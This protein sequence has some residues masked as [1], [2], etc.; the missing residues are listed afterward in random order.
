MISSKLSDVLAKRDPLVDFLAAIRRSWYIVVVTSLIVGS[1]ALGY[2]LLQQP[3]YRASATLYVTSAPE[4]TVQ[5]AYQGSLASQQRIESYVRL[6]DSTAVVK[7]AVDQSGLQISVPD[8][9]AMIS[10]SA[11]PGTVLLSVSVDSTEPAHAKILADS[12]AQSMSEYVSTLESP[13][14]GGSPLA[15]LT[16]VNPASVGKGYV[17]PRT[18]RVTSSALVVGLIMGIFFVFLLARLRG[19]VSSRSQVE[20]SSGVA[21]LSEIPSSKALS[22]NTGGSVSFDEGFSSEAEAFRRLRANLAFADVDKPRRVL[23]VTSASPS[24]GKTTISLNLATALSESGRRVLLVEG[25]LRRPTLASRLGLS[26]APGVSEVVRGDLTVEEASHQLHGGLLSVLT[27]GSRV[28]NP[29]ELVGSHSMGRLLQELSSGYEFVVVDSPPL[30]PVADAAVLAQLVD[31]V[32]V[33]ARIG[34]SKES[35][36]VSALRQLVAAHA[37]VLGLVLNGAESSSDQY[38]Y[39]SYGENSM[40][41]G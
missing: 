18:W 37:D 16:V 15:K 10:A 35:S 32:V 13:A 33:V 9:R 20:R 22:Q 26:R 17:S 40:A 31:G 1:A 23:L 8:A 39:S 25:D 30:L 3:I 19:R 6:V 11:E 36:L 5:S 27:A 29:S 24:E 7:R 2:C 28:P 14:G 21:V 4:D 38:R 12:V 41:S 34:V